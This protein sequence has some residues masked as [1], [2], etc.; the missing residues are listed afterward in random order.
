VQR[1]TVR[2]GQ[3]QR[4]LRQLR[5]PGNLQREWSVRLRSAV[6]RKAVRAGRLQRQ[7]R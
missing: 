7:L 4:Q 1:E 6:Q 2:A 3:L 5:Q